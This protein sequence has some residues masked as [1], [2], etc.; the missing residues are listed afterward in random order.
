MRTVKHCLFVSDFDQTLSFNDAGVVL[1][2][3]LG[4]P[5]FKE[6]V[7]GLSQLNLVQEG[8]ELAYLLRHDPAFRHVRKH[9]LEE[10][11]RRVRLKRNIDLTIN[12]LENGIDACTFNFFVVSAAPEEVVR[13]AL[14]GIVPPEKIIGTRFGYNEETG[15]INAVER[16]PAGFGK[17]RAVDELYARLGIPRERIVYVGDGSSDIHVMLH[18][19]R[20]NGLTIAVS[21]ARSI[22]QIARRTIVTEDALGILVPILEDLLGYDSVRI[23]ALFEAHGLLIQEWE[24]SRTDWLTIR[25]SPTEERIGPP[26][27][28]TDQEDAAASGVEPIEGSARSSEPGDP[29]GL[30]GSAGSAAARVPGHPDHSARGVAAG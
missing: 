3:M 25:P 27:R 6:K 5:D 8:A 22:A 15:E 2:D 29:A 4:I 17:V 10:V 30:I 13:A 12:L 28:P 11:G 20:G 21:E 18:V 1:S 7:H 26:L 9:H 24:R 14:E 23:R 19:N 16:V